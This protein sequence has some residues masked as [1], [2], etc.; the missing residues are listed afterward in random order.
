M[1]KLCPLQQKQVGPLVTKVK[2]SEK[3]GDNN[4]FWC[5][6]ERSS[7]DFEIVNCNSVSLLIVKRFYIARE[8]DFS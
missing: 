4:S 3:K 7:H 1:G 5:V 6:R 8:N 2:T